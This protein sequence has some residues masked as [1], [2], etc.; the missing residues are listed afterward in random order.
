MIKKEGFLKNLKDGGKSLTYLAGALLVI[1]FFIF[2]FSI[3]YGRTPLTGFFLFNQ[4]GTIPSETLDHVD[5]NN[6]QI[7]NLNVTPISN[8]N[9]NN[10]PLGNISN[11]STRPIPVSGGGGGGSSSQQVII[12]PNTG[13]IFIIEIISPA[14]DSGI[15]DEQTQFLF[16]I[17]GVSDSTL[18]DL[19]IDNSLVNSSN[20]IDS[21]SPN[22]LFSNLSIGNH[23]WEIICKDD[24]GKITS[25]SKRKITV[26]P[27]NIPFEM[28]SN[29]GDFDM[30]RVIGM[31][32]RLNGAGEIL[33]QD[34]I[35]L[36][37]FENISEYVK[38]GKNFISIDSVR[39]PYLNKPAILT[40]YGV[41]FE[42]PVI[43]RDGKP[44]FDCQILDYDGEN[45]TFYVSHFSN[46]TAGENSQLNIWDD[47]DVLTNPSSNIKFYANYT[48]VT[49]GVI[50]TGATCNIVFNDSSASMIYNST[51]TLYEYNRSFTSFGVYF[52]N[53]T[54]SAS[55][56]TSLNLTD[57]VSIDQLGGPSGAAL[58]FIQSSS[59]LI[60]SPGNHSAIA[61]NLS[62]ISLVATSSTQSWHGYYGNVSGTIQ[63]ADSTD[64]V[65]Y[66]WSETTPSGEVYASRAFDFNF[67]TIKCANSTDFLDEESRTGQSS[68]DVDS[69]SLTFNIKSHPQFYVGH[70]LFSQNG[71]NSTNIYGVSGAQSSYFYEVLLSDAA[72]NIAYTSL[73]ENNVVGFDSRSHDFEMIV[74]ENGHGTDTATS[75]YYFYAELT[76]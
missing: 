11:I 12:D 54:C 37:E 14:N 41:D 19:F 30:Q 8:N 4:N 70:I 62:E 38:I 68:S 67:I 58:T 60:D 9:A 75:I 29:L 20:E 16:N 48:N 32:F 69:V 76:R 53:I 6:P 49:S 36:S 63:L 47:T 34:A 61:G 10:Q 27:I 65:F 71:C 28:P 35:N 43:F 44:C 25:S 66:N 22:I 46:Y 18:C 2:L 5:G 52:Y 13:K 21:S 39:A 24:D 31:F 45:L 51:S 64:N 33:F 7:P 17:S 56:H 59:A 74:A 23:F 57:Y 72:S 55:G 40:L 3:S 50:I 1:A 73:M 26:L 15:F 42:N